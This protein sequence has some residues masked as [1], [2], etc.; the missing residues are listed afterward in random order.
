MYLRYERDRSNGLQSRSRRTKFSEFCP[1]GFARRSGILEGKTAGVGQNWRVVPL[2][3]GTP[4]FATKLAEG[5]TYGNSRR[6]LTT[7]EALARSIHKLLG[8]NAVVGEIPAAMCDLDSQIER[9]WAIVGLPGCRN[10]RRDFFCRWRRRAA[11]LC[12]IFRQQAMSLFEGWKRCDDVEPV[13]A[14]DIVEAG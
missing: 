4:G 12:K 9:L 6:K 2:K 14:N 3:C 5:E 1:L 11:T 7:I 13:V 8:Q 10:R